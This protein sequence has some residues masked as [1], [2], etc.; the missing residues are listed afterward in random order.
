M[1]GWAQHWM[2][3]AWLTCATA[4]SQP[5]YRAELLQVARLSRGKSPCSNQAAQGSQTR[6]EQVTKASVG[7]VHKTRPQ[8]CHLNTRYVHNLCC[9]GD[10]CPRGSGMRHPTSVPGACWSIQMYLLQVALHVAAR[11]SGTE[12]HEA[13]VGPSGCAAVCASLWR[14]GC[15]RDSQSGNLR[16]LKVGKLLHSPSSPATQELPG[17][18][19]GCQVSCKSLPTA[20]PAGSSIE[21]ICDGAPIS[22]SSSSNA[23]GSGQTSKGG[24]QR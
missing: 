12:A 7:M 2:R 17:Q 19:S 14:I 5:L 11:S 6:V 8:A 18:G 4:P 20:P 21:G 16:Q 22:A 15:R 3:H 9:G 23:A 1:P 24:R 13:Q 10:R